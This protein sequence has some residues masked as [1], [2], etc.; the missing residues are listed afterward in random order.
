MAFYAELLRRR[1]YCVC[2][3]N[4]IQF[5]RKFVYDTW[6]ASLTTEQKEQVRIAKEK[7]RKE[8]KYESY[9][10]LAKLFTID[11]LVANIYSRTSDWRY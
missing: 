2:E 6:Y 9:T 11:S 8:D 5:Y 1:W 4:W 7:K 10:A 3:E